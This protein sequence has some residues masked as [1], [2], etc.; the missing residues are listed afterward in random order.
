MGAA[1]TLVTPVLRNFKDGERLLSTDIGY[2]L[3][4]MV[5]NFEWVLNSSFFLDF[6]LL[7]YFVI[8][9]AGGSLYC[10]AYRFLG[11]VR[12]SFF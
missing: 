9:G 7:Y 6:E 12:S 2:A 5:V 10:S 3:T 11:F 4:G 1:A 8:S